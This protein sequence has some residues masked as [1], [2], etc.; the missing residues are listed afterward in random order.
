[1]LLCVVL[2]SIDGQK[3]YEKHELETF[4]KDNNDSKIQ[5]YKEIATAEQDPWWRFFDVL[6]VRCA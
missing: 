5:R 1:M 6:G 3:R 4:S 2:Q